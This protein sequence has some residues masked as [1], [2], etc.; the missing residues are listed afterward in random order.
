MTKEEKEWVKIRYQ[1]AK[2]REQKKAFCLDHTDLI[3]AREEEAAVCGDLIF[4]SKLVI[5]M[6]KRSLER[7]SLVSAAVQQEELI[8]RQKNEI[9]ELRESVSWWVDYMDYC[10]EVDERNATYEARY[11]ARFEKMLNSCRESCGGR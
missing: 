5:D 3:A 6:I 10:A 1:W 8:N 7:R 2:E 11:Q 9:N 4:S